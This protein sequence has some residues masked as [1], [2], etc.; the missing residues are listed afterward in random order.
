MK[1]CHACYIYER[2]HSELQPIEKIVYHQESTFLPEH[3][4]WKSCE[5]CSRPN[6]QNYLH[7]SKFFN[8]K[9]CHA[10][11]IYERRHSELQ[12]IEKIVYH[13]KS[14]FLPEHSEWKICEYC[15]NPNS[16]K[17]LCQS[18]FSEFKLCHACYNYE[19]IHNR[20]QP[21]EKIRDRQQ[22]TWNGL[23]CNFPE[24]N[25]C[26]YCKKPN[27]SKYLRQSKVF[28]YKLCHA[29]FYY[30][31]KHCQLIPPDKRSGTISSNK[32]LKTDEDNISASQ[33]YKSAIKQPA[34]KKIPE[35][36][37]VVRILKT[38]QSHNGIPL[39]QHDIISVTTD[40][41]GSY[42]WGEIKSTGNYVQILQEDYDKLIFTGKILNHIKA[43]ENDDMIS[44]SDSS[45]QDEKMND[46]NDYILKRQE[47]YP[48]GTYIVTHSIRARKSSEPHSKETRQIMKDTIIKLT[49]MKYFEKTKCIR[50]Q[51]EKGDWITI[52]NF[53]YDEVE[54]NAELL[55]KNL[56]IVK[57]EKPASQVT[58][59]NQKLA[60]KNFQKQTLAA[61]EYCKSPQ[62]RLVFSIKAQLKLC[63]SCYHYERSNG[64]LI[65]RSQRKLYCIASISDEEIFDWI[66]KNSS[67]QHLEPR[68]LRDN[69]KIGHERAKKIIEKYIR[70]YS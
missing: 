65:P 8:M 28:D 54:I 30:E 56:K 23:H 36:G 15:K 63:Y 51:T 45:H 43:K 41:I 17:Y 21:I 27:T 48:P 20:L 46:L 18:K 29:C 31:K 66:R 2:R 47:K 59:N 12:P 68:V 34:K 14:T 35:E 70:D 13:Q 11:Y 62:K 19:R 33:I 4:E 32:D 26:E 24:R 60:E 3:S 9:L 64:K 10:C 42:F 57:E 16:M 61:C 58:E 52:E 6:S 5:H 50:A 44:T 53:S 22:S 55:R 38:F 25:I 1:L 40:I 69:L 7:H 67:I 49:D 37:D 39:H